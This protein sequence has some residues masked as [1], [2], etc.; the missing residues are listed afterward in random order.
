MV[1]NEKISFNNFSIEQIFEVKPNPYGFYKLLDEL[2]KLHATC[3]LIKVV[4]IK[5][6]FF[7]NSTAP[8]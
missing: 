6:L 1:L 7:L 4:I 3:E 8:F 5:T 2:K